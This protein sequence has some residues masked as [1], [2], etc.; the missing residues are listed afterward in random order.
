MKFLRNSLVV[1]IFIQ[2]LKQPGTGALVDFQ[3]QSSQRGEVTLSGQ[4]LGWGLCPWKSE[5]CS[6]PSFLAL[7]TSEFC[8]GGEMVLPFSA[9]K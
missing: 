9:E 7:R 8:L 2:R 5:L 4:L 3:H 6:S 1:F